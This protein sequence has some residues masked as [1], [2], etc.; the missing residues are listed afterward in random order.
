MHEARAKMEMI[1]SAKGEKEMKIENKTSI[2]N[3]F[4]LFPTFE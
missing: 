1:K 4:H 3:K 2:S